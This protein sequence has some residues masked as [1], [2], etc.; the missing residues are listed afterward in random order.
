MQRRKLA[1]AAALGFGLALA[2]SACGGDGGGGGGG[3]GGEAGEPVKGGTLRIINNA[4]VDYYD[5]A[6]A[7]YTVSW[8]QMRALTRQLYSYDS[9][10]TGDELTVPVPDL[11]DGEAQTSDN[12]TF[13]FKIKSGI[14]YSQPATSEVK[15]EDFIYAVER[16]YDK[17]NPSSGQGY[18]NLI[19]GAQ[20][21][22]E[23]K[24]KTISGMKAEGN[25]LTIELIKPAADFIS[26]VTMPFFT[27]VPRDYASKFKV[28]PDYA[29]HLVGTG[30]YRLS[31]YTPNKEAE[32]VRNENWDAATDPLRKAYV[33]KFQIKIGLEPEA[34]QQAIERGDA[35]ISQDTQPP[36]A[37]LQRL[38]T[39]PGLKQRFGVFT[40]GC[41]RYMVLGTQ[42]AD[43]AIS[44]KEV[45]QAINYATDKIAIQRARGGPFAG[46]PASTILT[47]TLL[48]YKKADPYA[49]PDFK[50]DVNKAKELL[51]QAGYANGLTLSY[52][53]PNSGAGAR[54]NTAFQA[55]MDRVGIKLKSKTYAGSAVYTDSLQLQAKRAEHQ[56]GQAAWCPDWAGD[57]ARSF[58]VPLLDGRNITPSANNNYGSYNNDQVNSMIDQALAEPDR[59]KRGE[60]WSQIDQTIM[61]DAPWVP[62]LYDKTQIF[63]SERLKNFKFSPWTAEFDPT[64]IWLNPNTP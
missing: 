7:Y 63:W 12:K 47:P 11:A 9:T 6:N 29:K 18:S 28:G 19:K 55:A 45:R 62:F 13:T 36:T 42:S 37:A 10:K 25:T 8:T 44:K 22:G 34:I 51:S 4:D 54:V 21:F 3:G 64:S 57:A 56:I 16:M 32:F 17:T 39:D 43:G 46:D 30:P 49:T 58:L 26:I 20:E 31:K 52:V 33:D 61:Q 27:P 14:K 59:A 5:T 60:L 53:G 15:A 41:I 35:D 2:L 24:A 38:S 23:G 48:G 1:R 40:T 50:G